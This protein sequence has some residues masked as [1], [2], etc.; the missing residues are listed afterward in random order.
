VSCGRLPLAIRIAAAR[1]CSHP[2]WD[3]EHLVRRLRDQQQRLVELEAGQRGVTAA[4]DLSYQDLSA[5]LQ[6]TYR[7]LGLHPGPDIDPYAAAALLDTA[8]AET[9]RLLER[10]L[11]AHLLQEPNPGR[12]RFH[13][14][15]RA[16]AA[17][18]A[19]L[20]FRNAFKDPNV[21]YP[22]RVKGGGITGG[23][24]GGAG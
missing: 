12:Y 15:T 24:S 20:N 9:G 8:S 6:R 4:L 19:G 11:E 10:L 14:L 3:L 18:T 21:G 23:A 13:D 2:S 7:L 17:H 5:D 22:F 1:L 16:H